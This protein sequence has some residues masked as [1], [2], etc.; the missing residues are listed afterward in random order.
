M[1][2][3][4]KELVNTE[5]ISEVEIVDF[6]ATY[7]KLVKLDILKNDKFEKVLNRLG[8]TN[9]EDLYIF[10]ENSEYTFN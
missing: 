2:K 1:D 3:D 6:I 9:D 5:H 4:L 8:I 7:E 10:D